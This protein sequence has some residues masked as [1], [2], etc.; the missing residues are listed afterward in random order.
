MAQEQMSHWNTY[1]KK[2]D[3]RRTPQSNQK[4]QNSQSI[5][6]KHCAATRIP[7]L[8]VLHSGTSRSCTGQLRS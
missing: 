8:H 3:V 2:W 5:G 1:Y 6:A 7:P 4:I